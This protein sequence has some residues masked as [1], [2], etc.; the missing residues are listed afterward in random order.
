LYEAACE[1]RRIPFFSQL[2]EMGT[3]RFNQP[4][5]HLTTRCRELGMSLRIRA[6]N[7]HQRSP[8]QLL[9]RCLRT[10]RANAATVR[11]IVRRHLRLF[12]NLDE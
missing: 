2:V 7:C 6:R 8:A 4:L 5:E 3:T 9:E 10:A 12:F 11:Q 1:R